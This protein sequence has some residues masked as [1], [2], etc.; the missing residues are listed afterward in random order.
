MAEDR[1]DAG[2]SGALDIL[3]QTPLDADTATKRRGNATTMSGIK[4]EELGFCDSSWSILI[5]GTLNQIDT[6]K[7]MR[8]C[9]CVVRPTNHEE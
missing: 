4:G 5:Q 6:T 1:G 3:Q 2:T 7:R 9:T 8:K